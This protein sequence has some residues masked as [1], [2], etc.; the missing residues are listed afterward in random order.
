MKNFR[1]LTSFLLLAVGLTACENVREKV[2][3]FSVQTNYM[4]FTA[5]ASSQTLSITTTADWE[6]FIEETDNW[7]SAEKSKEGVTVS[8]SVNDSFDDRTG[9]VVLRASGKEVKVEVVQKGT[10]LE[11][12]ATPGVFEVPIEGGEYDFAVS[13]NIAWR[14]EI[15]EDWLTLD[16][17]S[18]EAGETGIKAKV[19]EYSG[20]IPR[21]AEVNLYAGYRKLST[22]TFNQAAFIAE[23]SI[24]EETYEAD[25]N[26][27]TKEI[28]V[29]AN[30]DWTVESDV[31]WITT[32]VTGGAAGEG[33]VVKLNI[34]EAIGSERTGKVEFTAGNV[35]ATLTVHQDKAAAKPLE[36]L[37]HFSD[38]ATFNKTVFTTALPTSSSQ[39]TNIG[40][41]TFNLKENTNYEFECY[42]SYITA[43]GNSKSGIIFSSGLRDGS[44]STNAIRKDEGF[45]YMKFPAIEGYK[46]TRVV[47]ITPAVASTT[48][49]PVYITT[50]YGSSNAEAI[51]NPLAY[52]ENVG[53]KGLAD[54]NV[55][56]L[57]NPAANTAYYLFMPQ[58]S[59]Y[60]S[61]FQYQ[62]LEINLTYTPVS[63]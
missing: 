31:K 40:V 46:L 60:T 36:I 54:P 8:A 63:E 51:A 43:L 23:I 4:E 6:P 21:S 26:G 3:V 29:S 44:Y 39:A 35:T 53:R 57:N 16:K 50:T 58:T 12:S 22:I 30:T 5:E 10:A 34:D 24:S 47:L 28:S 11:H 33:S 27:D 37:M 19:A 52:C 1:F 9:N 14:A 18:A 62:F 32:D 45:A 48:K 25:V 2:P 49:F 20:F 61:A 41:K 59:N 15:S 56:T 55:L 7:L 38:G 17:M 42:G 13:S